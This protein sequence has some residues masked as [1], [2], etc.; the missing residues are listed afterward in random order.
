MYGGGGDTPALSLALGPRCSLIPRPAQPGSLSGQHARHASWG[1]MVLKTRSYPPNP[2]TPVPICPAG[3]VLPSSPQIPNR[4]ERAGVLGTRPRLPAPGSLQLP[5]SPAALAGGRAAWGLSRRG[6]PGGL[7]PGRPPPPGCL[8]L[9]VEANR[10]GRRINN[11]ETF[12]GCGGGGGEGRAEARRSEEGRG[13]PHPARSLPPPPGSR[14]ILLTSMAEAAGSPL[15]PRGGRSRVLAVQAR[16]DHAAG[17]AGQRGDPA[18]SRKAA[19]AGAE[20]GRARGGEGEA[21]SRGRS[22][23]GSS[24]GRRSV[25]MGHRGKSAGRVRVEEGGAREGKRGAWRATRGAWPP[26]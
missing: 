25:G 11:P 6:N 16:R 26:I 23:V 18:R 9:R 4:E 5:R 13:S 14:T 22:V 24:A 19:A 21:G 7:K 8:E 2:H 10:L 12:N 15:R 20:K 1:V 17:C 3:S